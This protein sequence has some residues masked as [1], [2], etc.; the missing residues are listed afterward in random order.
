MPADADSR[1]STSTWNPDPS[2]QVPTYSGRNPESR[3]A[4]PGHPDAHRATGAFAMSSGLETHFTTDLKFVRVTRSRLAPRNC[5]SSTLIR[6]DLDL[7]L[8]IKAA[9]D[10]DPRPG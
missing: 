3:T 10:E 6:R 9:V 2:M 8:A 1:V 7:L 4:S 5:W